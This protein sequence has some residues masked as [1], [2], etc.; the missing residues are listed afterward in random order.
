MIIEVNN[1]KIKLSLENDN[2]KITHN[3][4][5]SKDSTVFT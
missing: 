1:N 4:L 2:V 5:V 3:A